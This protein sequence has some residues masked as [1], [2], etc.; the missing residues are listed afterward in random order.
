MGLEARPTAAGFVFGALNH[1]SPIPIYLR[2]PL[3]ATPR[4]PSHCKAAYIRPPVF[5]SHS[6]GSIT[7]QSPEQHGSRARRSRPQPGGCSQSVHQPNPEARRRQLRAALRNSRQSLDSDPSLPRPPLTGQRIRE[8]IVINR[9]I[10][11]RSSSERFCIYIR[12]D[13]R[14]RTTAA[15]HVNHTLYTERLSSTAR[16]RWTHADLGVFVGVFSCVQPSGIVPWGKSDQ[17]QI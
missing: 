1:T 11:P 16:G 15:P 7:A 3:C 13:Q 8:N 2:A 9:N 10:I 4:S 17:A 14:R 5:I 12:N 6:A